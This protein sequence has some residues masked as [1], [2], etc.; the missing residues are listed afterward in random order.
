[1][2]YYFSESELGF[3]CNEVNVAI[4]DDAVKINEEE[5]FALLEGQSSGKVIY[6]DNTGKPFLTEPPEPTQNELMAYA[7][8]KLT[9]LMQMANTRITPLERAVKLEM[10][11]DEEVERLNAWERYSVLL[12]RVKPEDAPDIDWPEK[13]E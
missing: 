2:N 12:S 10:A 4:P 7:E 9:A 11:T 6:A 1:M 8:N 3:Y 13:P 5:Y